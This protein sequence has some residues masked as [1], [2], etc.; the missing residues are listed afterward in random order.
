MVWWRATHDEHSF[1]PEQYT[2]FRTAI[3]LR[4]FQNMKA[5]MKEIFQRR[6]AGERRGWRT[7][8][9][10]VVALSWTTHRSS[11][12]S[13]VRLA[14]FLR[15]MLIRAFCKLRGSRISGAARKSCSARP[16]SIDGTPPDPFA[17][18]TANSTASTDG[19][20]IFQSVLKLSWSR[21]KIQLHK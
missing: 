13:I 16:A 14:Y 6:H 5:K 10:D 3:S 7:G 12:N 1:P 11:R 9:D 20:K 17:H 2:D 15:S 21:K 18:A 19:C 8:V 4:I